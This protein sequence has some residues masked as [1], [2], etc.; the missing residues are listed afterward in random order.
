MEKQFFPLDRTYADALKEAIPDS[1]TI[2][3][4]GNHFPLH[5]SL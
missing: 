2:V 3:Q 5:P 4:S 1:I